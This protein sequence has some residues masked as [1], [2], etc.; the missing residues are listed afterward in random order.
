MCIDG[1]FARHGSHPPSTSNCPAAS[2]TRTVNSALIRAPILGM[3]AA[4]A[5][6]GLDVSAPALPVGRPIPIEDLLAVARNRAGLRTRFSRRYWPTSPP[7]PRSRAARETMTGVDG[8]DIT[9]YVAGRPMSTALPGLLHLHGGGMA[10]LSAGRRRY[11]ATTSPPR[12]AWSSAS[13]SATPPARW[14]RIRSRPASTTAP[15]RWNG[16]THTATNWV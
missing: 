1:S 3:V 12:A 4:L 10:I 5:P 9:L 6:L 16:C 7:P 14:V 2:A 13:S 8:N 15:A 11:G